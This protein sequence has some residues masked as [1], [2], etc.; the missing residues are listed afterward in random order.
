MASILAGTK[1]QA[2]SPDRVAAT[3][4]AAAGLAGLVAVALVLR[5]VPVL[6]VPSLDW[7][8]ELF[9]A[10]EQA[11][12][13][14]FGTGLIPW[15]FQFGVR[16]WLLPGAIAGIMEAARILGDGP[17]VYLTAIAVVFAALATAPVV[18]VFLWARR[19]FGLAGAL[20]A[21]SVVATAPDLVYLGARTLSEVVA[22]H[23]LVI[24]L[25]LIEPGHPVAS[26]RRLVGAGLLLGLAA[27]L[28]IQIA[29]A[30]L[31]MI[32]WRV[33]RASVMPV[34]A[35]L[36]V[37]IAFAAVLDASTLGAP[38]A[39]ITRY[40][41]DN[42]FAGVSSFYGVSDASFYAWF[43]VSLW[44][45]GLA[46]PLCLML[47][48][49]KRLPLALVAALVI[50]TE[51][52]LV[53]HKEYRFLYPA[54]LLGFMLAGFGLAQVAQHGKEAL[55]A[56]GIEPTAASFAAA[57]TCILGWSIVSL[58][59]WMAPGFA[60]L[61]G[62]A[63]DGLAAASF[64]ARDAKACGIGLSLD[65][66][67]HD[68]VYGSY[69]YLSR[70]VPRYWF[71]DKAELTATAPAFN[72]LIAIRPPPPQLGYKSVQCF[73]A[74]CVFERAGGC[75]PLPMKSLPVPDPLQ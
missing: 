32:A 5:L 74:A 63:H 60:A 22:A 8:D 10:T 44:S 37:A 56:R 1:R 68:W 54:I 27:A 33:S 31:V 15:E 61:R 42:L 11:H 59:I 25:Y 67:E 52:Q 9:Q 62:V 64:V 17:D 19:W 20:V 3:P 6:L 39:S 47:L 45:V 21:G 35:G 16:S 50:V 57:A 48:G 40:V 7:P 18:C 71:K 65:Q 12:R 30:I 13:L 36:A 2:G 41:A 23:L 38:L 75:I 43:E 66:G 49:A 69:T 70:P 73:G 53:G 24:A 55:E 26:R 29:P 34:L 4:A 51:H 58:E 14:V 28:R 72:T 46:L